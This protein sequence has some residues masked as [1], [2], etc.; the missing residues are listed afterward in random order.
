M[1]S[2]GW[3]GACLLLHVADEVI[4]HPRSFMWAQ[5]SHTKQG[6]TADSTTHPYNQNT[7]LY[8]CLL[9]EAFC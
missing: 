7:D 6:N 2:L 9:V 8:Q 1:S 4:A 5:C 3:V